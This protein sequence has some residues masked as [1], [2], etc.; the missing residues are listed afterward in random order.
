MALEPRK[1]AK[2]GSGMDCSKVDD[3]VVATKLIAKA[4]AAFIT[5]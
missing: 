1:G 5:L 3:E 4:Q 2:L